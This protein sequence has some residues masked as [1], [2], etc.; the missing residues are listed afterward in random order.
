MAV[1]YHACPAAAYTF[2]LNSPQIS[3]FQDLFGLLGHRCWHNG[4]FLKQL[5]A[6]SWCNGTSCRSP[7]E[8]LSPEG[9]RDNRLALMARPASNLSVVHGDGRRFSK[10]CWDCYDDC[11]HENKEVKDAIPVWRRRGG[12]RC[13]VP[14]W[15]KCM[16]VH[17]NRPT[18]TQAWLL[19]EACFKREISWSCKHSVKYYM[20]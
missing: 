16:V 11:V 6:L 10:V 4:F 19:G 20:Q 1:P 7:V 17:V 9:R 15:D 8:Q 12:E 13:V 18:Y 14:G 5:Q 3:C 2:T